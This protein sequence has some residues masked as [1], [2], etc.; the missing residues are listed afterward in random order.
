MAECKEL[1]DIKTSAG[2][3][4]SALALNQTSLPKKYLS[5]RFLRLVIQA[6]GLSVN[7][8]DVMRELKVEWNMRDEYHGF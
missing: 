6:N 1:G 3:L 4:R 5:E 2:K 7:R 8:D